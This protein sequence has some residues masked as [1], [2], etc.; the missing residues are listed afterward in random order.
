[1]ATNACVDGNCF[2]LDANGRLSLKTGAPLR[3]TTHGLDIDTGPGVRI[4]DGKLM[5]DARKWGDVW[6]CTVDHS[7]GIFYDGTN[8]N[9]VGPPRNK[10]HQ[11]QIDETNGNDTVLNPGEQKTITHALDLNFHADQGFC[12]NLL[13]YGVVTV[14]YSVFGLLAGSQWD[15]EVDVD[16]DG[17]GFG[18]L[19]IPVN[20][21]NATAGS[22]RGHS[23]GQ[24]LS[25]NYAKGD[26]PHI[27]FRLQIRN[28]N[29][30]GGDTFTASLMGLH[31]NGFYATRND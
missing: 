31:F 6:D 3:C 25:I 13:L 27:V 1:M 23:A 14:D 2:K 9:L 18:N 24:V 19:V 4:T 12:E 8:G 17:G 28:L 26:T 7:S 16:I 5:A 21:G 30:S 29:S 11:V 20:W 15:V 22:F 10:M